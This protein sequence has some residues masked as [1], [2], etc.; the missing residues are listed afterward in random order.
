MIVF[1]VDVVVPLG[2][3]AAVPHVVAVLLG[4]RA[5][6]RRVPLGVAVL[7]SVLTMAGAVLSPP[8]GIPWMV[9]ANRGLSLLAIWTTAL[10]GVARNRELVQRIQVLERLKATEEEVQELRGLIA[11]CASCKRIRNDVGSWQQLESYI[12]EHSH[13]EFTHGLCAACAK[14][15]YPNFEAEGSS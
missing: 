13:A 14:Q 3:A 9:A 4:L 5:A 1:S 8:G 12:E 11:I 10:L 6:D 2:V 15:L 7:C